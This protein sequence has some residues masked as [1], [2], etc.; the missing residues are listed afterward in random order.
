MK[1]HHVIVGLLI[2]LGMS[3]YAADSRVRGYKT[4]DCSGSY[5][6]A[7]SYSE[8]KEY[9]NQTDSFGNTWHFESFL[10]VRNADKCLDFNI[11]TIVVKGT[12]LPDDSYD[13]DDTNGDAGGSGRA[14]TTIKDR[15]GY[16]P[17]ENF[18]NEDNLDLLDCWIDKAAQESRITNWIGEHTDA[19]WNGNNLETRE[20]WD[21]GEHRWKY[22]EVKYTKPENA[23]SKSKVIIKAWIYAINI[24]NDHNL[25][26][27]PFKH[28]VLYWQMHEFVHV[29][30]AV[31]ERDD[32]D[33]QFVP[34]K[35]GSWLRELE[36]YQTIDDWWNWLF[37]T[38][39]PFN[40]PNVEK[41]AIYDTNKK[42]WDELFEKKL[43]GE[44][45]IV[46]KKK[47]IDEVT[48]WEE[49]EKYF[50]KELGYLEAEPN[51]NY[52]KTTKIDC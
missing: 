39:A 40:A 17:G 19:T 28:L 5:L 11:P 31:Q 8:L 37:E 27:I 15:S 7:G 41:P 52:D 9:H 10:Y 49:L 4:D 20:K 45:L 42:R 36:A 12:P 22:G 18:D 44:E 33:T 25:R 51:T 43:N 46:D 34:Y 16:N 47:G 14:P 6:E 23:T 32:E 13:V 48:E 21:I 26:K 1:V 38:S 30:Q 3:T 29:L 35:S 50:D 24:G 2:I